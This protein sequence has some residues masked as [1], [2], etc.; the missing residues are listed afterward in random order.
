MV[1]G[2]GRSL[3]AP[4]ADALEAQLRMFARD[5]GVLYR[6]QKER[7]EQLEEALASLKTTYLETIRSLA[8]VVEAKDA[9]TGQHLERCRAY[10]VV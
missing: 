3:P 2:P 7:A 10:G 8:F 5:I 6:D 9:Y 4:E 1:D